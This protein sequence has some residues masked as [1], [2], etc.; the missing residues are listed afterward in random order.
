VEFAVVELEEGK[1]TF[2]HV[3]GVKGGRLHGHHAFTWEPVSVDLGS[4]IHMGLTGDEPTFTVQWT[5]PWIEARLRSAGQLPM[6]AA[7]NPEDME[8]EEDDEADMS[9][10]E[11]KRHAEEIARLPE[12]LSYQSGHMKWTSV[13]RGRRRKEQ[14]HFIE[15]GRK[16]KQRQWTRKDVDHA[17]GYQLASVFIRDNR[18]LIYD[19]D[20]LFWAMCF[21]LLT[22]NEGTAK[23]ERH[24][25]GFAKVLRG[26]LAEGAELKPGI[27]TEEEFLGAWNAGQA[28]KKWEGFNEILRAWP[29]VEEGLAYAKNAPGGPIADGDLRELIATK[30]V[31]PYGLGITKFSFALEC[32]GQDV[33]CLD[34]W[35]L[36]AMGAVDKPKVG[37]AVKDVV[38]DY[39]PIFGPRGE[40]ALGYE[41]FGKLNKQIEAHTQG[42]G[43]PI[44]PPPWPPF[45]DGS[46]ALSEWGGG[47]LGC[48]GS[49][50]KQKHFAVKP[51]LKEYEWWE[52]RLKKTEFYKEAKAAGD[53]NPLCQAQ[54]MTWEDIMRSHPKSNLRVRFATHSP[55]WAATHGS[56]A[57]RAEKIG[58]GKGIA[59]RRMTARQ[60]PTVGM[61]APAP[62]RLLSKRNPGI[63][64]VFSEALAWKRGEIAH[65]SSE[66]QALAGTL[67]ERALAEF[68]S[69]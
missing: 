45:S 47:R 35:M 53:P 40:G 49:G 55:L 64:R 69:V 39:I 14:K 58:W 37:G 28:Q 16:A 38:G 59:A 3:D 23:A 7:A 2:M 1:Q 54:W 4:V 10:G 56:A 65:A 50:E 63:G 57:L 34:R 8:G 30:F 20:N 15:A 25:S 21:A 11:R 24:L 60:A 5:M 26:K 6:R 29:K 19:T 36:R 42:K 68:A 67:S 13:S 12:N 44:P 22:A 43:K 32:C 61:E 62:L 51:C 46:Y 41:S 31:L 52:A 48:R 33:A 9:E 17:Y 66:A 27:I 18:T